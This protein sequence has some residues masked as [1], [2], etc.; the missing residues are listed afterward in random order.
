[1][2]Q[3]KTAIVGLAIVG[4]IVWYWAEWQRCAEQQRPMNPIRN[5]LAL[6]DLAFRRLWRNRSF[7][8]I[9]VG[10]WLV[11]I[12]V[13][14]FV[15]YPLLT[16]RP[17]EQELFARF[18]E[19]MQSMRPHWRA[20]FMPVAEASLERWIS[21]SLPMIRWVQVG[22]EGRSY[23]VGIPAL[24]GLAAALIGLWFRPPK[25]MTPDARR[26]LPWPIH[27]T[28]AC[29]VCV[30]L[31]WA[32]VLSGNRIAVL[33]NPVLRS[34]LKLFILFTGAVWI[35]LMCQLVLQIGAGQ[36]WHLHR[37]V[38]A[39][40]NR[41]LPI[42]WLSVVIDAPYYA[43]STFSYTT[44]P[45]LAEWVMRLPTVLA[46]T[47]LFVPWIILQ[48]QANL[49]SAVMR[50]FRILWDHRWDLSVFLLRYIAVVLPVYAFFDM[51][52]FATIPTSVAA[53]LIL[54]YLFSLAR[55]LFE[56]VLLLTMIVLYT[57]LREVEQRAQ[58]T[59]AVAP[60]D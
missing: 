43:L 52:R 57:N 34:A 47:L 20:G 48:E 35:A 17:L 37:G 11:S 8:A 54:G 4:I 21:Q 12:A 7:L 2:V 44:R 28:L 29:F 46:V 59:E 45:I 24:G 32:A 9:L 50:N 27:I 5:P 22:L 18:R 56:L 42:A 16:G 6:F 31:A 51:L 19:Y 10:C 40:T 15:L 26:R 39:A 36:Y 13:N 23:V 60:V 49:W 14:D 25:W 1:M 3:T 30:G 33:L 55:S 58:A 53:Y 38:L 41:W